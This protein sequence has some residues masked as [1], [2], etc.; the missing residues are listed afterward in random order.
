MQSSSTD[1]GAGSMI[2]S[3]VTSHWLVVRHEFVQFVCA[4]QGMNA[5]RLE[6]D[7]LIEKSTRPTLEGK[8]SHISSY[9]LLQTYPTRSAETFSSSLNRIDGDARENCRSYLLYVCIYIY[10]YMR[11]SIHSNHYCDVE[12]IKQNLFRK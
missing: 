7:A 5:R 10:S 11:N 4:Y 2:L 6:L 8:K 12:N 3:S 1:A 9:L